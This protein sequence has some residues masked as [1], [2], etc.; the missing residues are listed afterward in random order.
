MSPDNVLCRHNPQMGDS[1]K[2]HIIP[3]SL[4]PV[5]LTLVHDMPSA[6]HPGRERT[7]QRIKAI[8]GQQCALK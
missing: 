4:V 7:L 8:I 1:N 5:I 6:G 3:E 2:Q